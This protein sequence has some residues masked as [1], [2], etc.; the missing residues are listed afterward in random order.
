MKNKSF[1]S[2]LLLLPIL[3]VTTSLFPMTPLLLDSFL[4][5]GISSSLIAF[6]WALSARN[7][8]DLVSYPSVLFYLTI[9]RLGLNIASTRLILSSG[10]ASPMITSLGKFLASDSIIAGTAVLIILFF[11]NFLLIAKGGER[12]AEVRARFI[13]EALPG[14][15]MALDMSLNSGRKSF[16]SIE[17]LREEVIQE[18]EFFSSMEGVFRFVK[19]DAVIAL[20]I[21]A[22]NVFS[23]PF[24]LSFSSLTFDK[25]WLVIL[26]DGLVGQIPAILTSVGAATT[27]SKVGKQKTFVHSFTKDLQK[28]SKIFFPASFS[29]LL[30][31][32][33][34][35]VPFTPTFL[36]GSVLLLIGLKLAH[37]DQLESEPKVELHL[38]IADM[39]EDDIKRNYR[40]TALRIYNEL[41]VHFPKNIRI[42]RSNNSGA[43]LQVFNFIFDLDGFVEDSLYRKMS[44][45]AHECVNARVIEELLVRTEAQWGIF[46]DEIIPMKISRDSLMVVCKSLLKDGISLHLFPYIV[47]SLSSLPSNKVSLDRVVEHVRKHLGDRVGRSILGKQKKIHVVTVDPYVEQL[48]GCDYPE[49]N[50]S[51]CQKILEEIDELFREP[52]LHSLEKE[53]RAV[54]TGSESRVEMK[55]I[56]E[57]K[58]PDL[59]ILSY[60]ELPKDIEICSLGTVSEKVLL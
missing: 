33:L 54:V 30:F 16:A 60:D 40:F 23:V 44:S 25:L 6:L 46:S 3:V 48:I 7:D 10:E 49:K 37:K 50:P 14:K 32:F 53:V 11:M 27:I 51:V 20:L 13:L 17:N 47:D 41:G 57:H 45:L 21:L 52:L 31:A 19:G 24:L 36:S 59:L 34:P 29:M 1:E 38:P 8:K 28:H 55:K 26:G 15:Q 22:V 12:I 56:I 35:G 43:F 9:F 18:S 42:I 4:C 5:L 39:R 2:W 58:F